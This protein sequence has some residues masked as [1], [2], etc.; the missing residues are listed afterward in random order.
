[1]TFSSRP[2]GPR[3][4]LVATHFAEYSFELARALATA[5]AE[6]L[7]VANLENTIGE[8]G[9]AFILEGC[10]GLRAHFIRKSRNPF[11]FVWQVL[12]LSRVIRAFRPEVL[13]VQEDSKDVLA[14]A[15]PFLP[16]VPMLL[17]MHDPKPH[18]GA[19]TNVRS[20]SRHGFYIAQLRRRADALVVHGQRLV[21]DA[22]EVLK[23]R[24][25]VVHVVPH[26]P[27]GEALAAITAVE[28][29]SERCLFFGRI[30]AYKGLNHF[31]ATVRL[32]NER[33][34]PAVGVVAGR[35]S[36]LEAHRA[37]LKNNP[38]FELIEKFLTPEEVVREFMRAGVVVMP[39]DNATQSGVAAYA[40][41]VGRAVVAFDVGAL[42]E[43]VHEGETGLLVQH[44]DLSALTDAVRRVI[45]DPSLSKQLE[46]GARALATNKYS[47]GRIAEQTLDAYSSLMVNPS[48]SDT[49]PEHSEVAR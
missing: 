43:M 12:R 27:L 24:T 38:M 28:Q 29:Q 42:H 2:G 32:L 11:I 49:D 18:T 30:E 22:R 35:G 4:C 19:D 25:V 31:I 14:A 33:G 1:M 41:G 17:T 15:L 9:E 26:G 10:G 45:E 8:I 23:R 5:G 21:A 47:W 37:E 34:V 13:H 20:R 40:I 7:V 46:K 39:Y 3:V 48:R 6:V 16:R 36:D 44:G